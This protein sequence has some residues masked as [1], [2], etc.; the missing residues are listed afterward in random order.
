MPLFRRNYFSISGRDTELIS[1]CAVWTIRRLEPGTKARAKL[2]AT[3]THS[4]GNSEKGQGST[5]P[6]DITNSICSRKWKQSRAACSV[7]VSFPLYGCVGTLGC[8]QA[9][10]AGKGRDVTG[11][12]N[13]E[14]RA[15]FHMPKQRDCSYI[16]K[17]TSALST[18]KHTATLP[19]GEP[20]SPT[21][22][23]KQISWKSYYNCHATKTS[24]KLLG[25][26]SP[27]RE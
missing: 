21:K 3:N 26:I 11:L 8:R 1:T 4:V 18:P 9:Y 14:S 12:R 7:F 2:F 13:R 19:L 25:F 6:L 17:H 24:D 5:E 22:I 23:K 15:Q 16:K 27:I 20:F 10:S